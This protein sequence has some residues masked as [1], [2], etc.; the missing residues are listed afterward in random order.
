MH[1]L[2]IGN[3]DFLFLA[4]FVKSLDCIYDF[5]FHKQLFCFYSNFHLFNTNVS[6]SLIVDRNFSKMLLKWSTLLNK[7]LLS[8]ML[9]LFEF[10][11]AFISNNEP[12]THRLVGSLLLKLSYKI[13]QISLYIKY[14]TFYYLISN[15]S[16][17]FIWTLYSVSF[18][19]K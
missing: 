1:D 9:W 3:I 18:P 12:I 7:L 10:V 15:L 6:N 16:I 8:I 13:L 5:F 17:S 11:T 14:F 19:I 4:R 2:C